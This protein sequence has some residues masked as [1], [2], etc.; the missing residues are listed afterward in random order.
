MIVSDSHEFVF[1]HI[2]KCAGGSVTRA[3]A[4]ISRRELGPHTGMPFAV[5]HL[6]EKFDRYFKF[7]FV[8]NPWDRMVSRY[9][10]AKQR[11]G[12]ME[13]GGFHE[14]RA[15]FGAF[16]GW[17]LTDSPST[18][19]HWLTEPQTHT[20]VMV[21]FVGRVERMQADFDV[22]CERIGIA[23]RE[24]GVHRATEHGPYREYYDAG[25]RDVIA[26]AYAQDI[27]GFGYEF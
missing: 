24:L 21:D 16:V 6:G 20:R 25:L 3:L 12:A 9:E 5:E 1:F 26:G 7:A 14:S 8:R 10:Y 19:W 22:V 15:S 18:Q 23:P 13:P 17:Q 2:P 11:Q 27:E 4:D